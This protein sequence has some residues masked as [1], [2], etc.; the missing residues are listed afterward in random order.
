MTGW[1]KCGESITIEEVLREWVEREARND[2][3]PDADSSG[4]DHERLVAELGDTYKEPVDPVDDPALDW[5]AVQLDG[6]EVGEL[7]TFPE[8]A[9]DRLSGDS[10]VSGAVERLRDP[11][12][13]EQF[14][15]ATKKIEWFTEHIESRAFDA[16]VLWQRDGKWP[17]VLLDGNHRACAAHWTAREG[18]EPTVTVHLGYETLPGG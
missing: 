17:P 15:G 14:P 5:K 10:T 2:E 13:A 16:A 9:W 7:G 8:P 3:Y 6:E 12:V 4:W 18:A 1:W 11:A